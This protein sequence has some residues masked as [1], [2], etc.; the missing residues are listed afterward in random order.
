MKF[1]KLTIHNIA[2]IEDAVIDFE[3]QPL[4]NSEV[5][6]ITGKTGAGK[7]TILDAICLALYADTPRLDNTKMQ[8]E[9]NDAGRDVKINDPRQLMRRNTGEAF[10]MLT[11]VGNN[12]VHYE[13]TW[14]VA[15]ARKKVTG[16]LQDKEWHL[17]NIDADYTL[18]KKVEIEAEIKM[19]VGLDFSQFCRTT[20][21]AQGEFT[22]FLNSKDDEK[23]EILE[24]ITGVDIYSRIGAKIF[25]VTSQKKQDWEQSQQRVEGIRVLAESE[26][27]ERQEALNALET[28]TKHINS[29]KEKETAK[30][31]WIKADNEFNKAVSD[32]KAALERAM[33]TIEKEEFKQQ[34]ALVRDW[35]ETI[36][37]RGWLT[38]IIRSSEITAQQSKLLEELKGRYVEVLNGQRCEELK[39][40]GIEEELKAIESYL[41]FEKVRIPAYENS[42]KILGLLRV[43][44]DGRGAIAKCEKSIE[45]EKKTLSGKLIPDLEKAKSEVNKAKAL[46]EQQEE[47]YKNLEETV[48]NLRLPELREQ[49]QGLI[50]L[51]SKIERAK[52]RIATLAKEKTRMDGISENLIQ[53]SAELE[54]KKEEAASME[55][56]V[57]DAELELKIRKEA[58]D[59]Q[60]DTVNKFASTL[61]QKLHVGDICPVCRQRIDKE[62]PHEG[63]LY[64]L[65]SD[66]K[67][68][69]EK[70]QK[71][72]DG[73]KD[74]YVKLNAEIKTESKSYER[75][76]VA[77]EK[78]KSIANAE[79]DAVC[80]CEACGIKSL[81]DSTLL[82]LHE[83]QEKTE[84]LKRELEVRIG[85]GE[86]KE[87]ENKKIREALYEKRKELEK[88]NTKVAEEEKKI[89][90]CNGRIVTSETL[91]QAKNKEIILAQ[92]QASELLEAGDWK[93]D[94]M[95]HPEV[96]SL[97]LEH[98]ADSYGKY[99]S[100]RQQ[101]LTQ[102]E[103]IKANIANIASVVRNILQTIPVWAE[104]QPEAEKEV[105][106][107]FEKAN[108]IN[109]SVSTAISQLKMA[110]EANVKNLSLLD[111][112][113]LENEK[114]DKDRLSALNGYT[115]NDIKQMQALLKAGNDA[116]VAKK[117]LHEKAT[118]QHLCHQQ[119]KPEMSDEDTFE[120]LLVRIEEQ[121]NL[122]EEILGKKVRINQELKADKE[123]KAER[124]ALIE[125]AEKKKVD[126]EKWSRMN[127]LIGDANGH[128]FRKIAQSYVLTSLVHSANSY[129]KTLTDRYALRVT[130][131]TFVIMIEDAYQGYVSRAASTI[132]GGES[133]LVSLSLAL[134][135]SDIGQT[136]SADILFIDEGFGTLSGEPLQ[137]AVNTLRS[138][139]TKAGRH[140]GIIS[141]VEELQERI[142]I[143][144]QLIQEGKNSCSKISVVPEQ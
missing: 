118:Q 106:N 75:D 79:K 35:N 95:E 90:D 97:S 121:G 6:L 94:W 142:P 139:H 9:T 70:A 109:A 86:A 105:K 50:N 127:Q 77:F 123:S 32:A 101:I 10:A 134:A 76:K 87:K 81:S 136:L 120:N 98:A 41:E 17:R 57:H 68:A 26:I 24:K 115:N 114:I 143:Q 30:L 61:R 111:S 112:F 31:E 29:L 107:L 65:V 91:A 71:E 16:K 119:N 23:A 130:P 122:L 104:I 133:F 83:L 1:Q 78:D 27:A 46:L 47:E 62:L 39:K 89:N 140:V 113:L 49:N 19:A 45:K 85:D 92:E 15:R 48:A 28:E 58:F 132:S 33:D 40:N 116:V 144:I 66:L 141:H 93:I 18:V 52:D 20:M 117:T 51:L 38:E 4:S 110:E 11:F 102:Y 53:R 80:A 2:S 5:F 88:L 73:L 125:E 67:D 128:K 7:S 25:E 37:A 3:A 34:D 131:G 124:G 44:I 99:V 138:L 56:R 135:L 59:K 55:L 42:Q 63:E 64:A 96:F 54:K 84:T 137:N 74:K 36:D 14:S 103:S 126:Y 43:V 69:F 72:Y 108:E 22:R 8:G 129:M 100:K 82:Q 13:A 60:S 12:G 21:L